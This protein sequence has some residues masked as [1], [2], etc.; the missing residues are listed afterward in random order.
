MMRTSGHFTIADLDLEKLN[1]TTSRRLVVGQNIMLQ[2]VSVKAGSQPPAHAH[3][4]EQVIWIT[5]G[6]MRYRLGDAEARDCAPG[7]LVVIPGDVRHETWFPE[8]TDLIEIFS[9]IREDLLPKS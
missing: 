6:R 2:L 5:S 3:P 9:P 1:E 8:D 4:H 7:S